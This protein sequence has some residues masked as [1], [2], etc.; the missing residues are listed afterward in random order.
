MELVAY[1]RGRDAA[2]GER[3]Q[4]ADVRD[5]GMADNRSSGQ[6]QASGGGVGGAHKLPVDEGAKGPAGLQH[7]GDL[8]RCQVRH[9]RKPDH[10]DAEDI[11]RRDQ[12]AFG[13]QNADVQGH[14]VVQ[15][16]HFAFP[17][18]PSKAMSVVLAANS[19]L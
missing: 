14:A 1:Q 7:R 19:G 17:R 11:R 15:V 5:A 12:F 2:P 6:S 3:R 18:K 16:G 10:G 8:A 13:I 9:R 4:H